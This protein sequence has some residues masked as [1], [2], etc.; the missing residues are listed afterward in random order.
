MKSLSLALLFLSLLACQNS[1]N[2]LQTNSLSQ[3]AIESNDSLANNTSINVAENNFSEV[4][5][6]IN[7]LEQQ[8]ME[9]EAEIYRLAFIEFKD[10]D[11]SKTNLLPIV[12]T[13]IDKIIVIT[14][15]LNNSIQ[16]AK[17]NIEIIK[18]QIDKN[19][20]EYEKI[21]QRIDSILAKIQLAEDSIEIFKE[22]ILNVADKAL[23][24]INNK[25]DSLNIFNPLHIPLFLAGQFL[26]NEIKDIIKKLENI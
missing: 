13:I 19:N 22:K 9:L 18:S 4:E 1:L 5:N 25:L 3:S 8:F 21:I 12:D 20:P 7:L 15:T 6:N 26:K 2:S 11:K 24:I 10:V 16:K 14:S 23:T 17:L